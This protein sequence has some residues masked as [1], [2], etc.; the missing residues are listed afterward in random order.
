MEPCR[1]SFPILVAP[2]LLSLFQA[3][4]VTDTLYLHFS[5]QFFWGFSF[6]RLLI[7]DFM[8][9]WRKIG[10]CSPWIWFSRPIFGK[11]F[12]FFWRSIWVDRSL[13]A[14]QM[15]L[16]IS[17]LTEL[18]GLIELNFVMFVDMSFLCWLDFIMNRKVLRLT[19]AALLVESLTG[20][21]MGSSHSMGNNTLCLLTNLQTVSMVRNWKFF[22]GSVN[23]SYMLQYS[24]VSNCW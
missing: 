2:S 6:V 11:I 1:F 19:L 18:W 13:S 24:E 20:S 7:M 22:V 17:E 12:R 15:V 3:K 5:V 16:D 9:L 23:G 4:M 14:I 8:Q 10:W 21:K